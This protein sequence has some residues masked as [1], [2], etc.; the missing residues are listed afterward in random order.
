MSTGV[1]EAT[2]YMYAG[3]VIYEDK[4]IVRFIAIKAMSS[5]REVHTHVYY[6]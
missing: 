5:I 4:D 6:M 3:L 1:A 2:R